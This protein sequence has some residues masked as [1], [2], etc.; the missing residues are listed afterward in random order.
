MAEFE[1]LGVDLSFKTATNLTGSQYLLM[2]ITTAN[3]V[4]VCTA[5]HEAAIGVLQ[6]NPTSGVEAVVRC[7]SGV[8]T[9]VIAGGAITVGA[10]LETDAA[11]KVV[12]FDYV[13]N[14]NTECYMVGTALTAGGTDKY[15][16]MLTRFAPSSFT[17]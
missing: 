1:N 9:R 15:I 13:S 12:A 10:T 17:T 7:R 11:G 16:T 3:T 4:A 14:G 6:N 5:A 8:K 2:T